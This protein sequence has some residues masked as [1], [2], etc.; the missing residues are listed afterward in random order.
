M[1]FGR[2]LSFGRMGRVQ[3]MTEAAIQFSTFCRSRGSACLD[4]TAISAAI[5]TRQF[6]RTFSFFSGPASS[7][8]LLLPTLTVTTASF[9]AAQ[10]TNTSSSGRWQAAQ[11]TNTSNGRRQAVPPWASCFIPLLLV[12]GR[13]FNSLKAAPLWAFRP[14][15]LWLFGDQFGCC[16]QCCP[17]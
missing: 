8:K 1:P 10:Q 7:D 4:N 16:H 3:S 12:I 5:N 6:F 9:Q 11:Q 17:E 2:T 14:L 15:S 13:P